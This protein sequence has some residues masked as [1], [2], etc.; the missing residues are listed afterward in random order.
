MNNF[1]L[2]KEKLITALNNLKVSNNIEKAES[3]LEKHIGFD[4]EKKTFLGHFKVYAMTQGRFWPE[5][6]VI[7]Y[8]SA[9]GMGKTTFV[10]NLA[11]AMGRDRETISLAG[12]KESGE[13]SIL[14]DEKKPSLVAW[15]IKKNGLKNPVILLDEL[16]KVED[17]EIQK[18]LIQLFKDYKEGKKFT[19]GI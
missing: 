15:A 6:K 4:K 16:E 12:F 7:C 10:K 2:E 1:Q 9:P 18:H 13:Y 19:D 8:S 5:R 11:N 17:K 14:G 3:D